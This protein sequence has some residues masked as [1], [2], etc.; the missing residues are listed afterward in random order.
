MSYKYDKTFK[1]SY[2]KAIK[3][4]E[5]DECNIYVIKVKG[6]FQAVNESS[7]ALMISADVITE[8]KTD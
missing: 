2:K 1:Q 8:I 3:L 6:G 7:L 4:S 5:R